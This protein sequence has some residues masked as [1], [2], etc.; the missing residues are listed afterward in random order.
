MK[1]YK[2]IIREMINNNNKINVIREQINA[3]KDAEKVAELCAKLEKI[4]V[5]GQILRDNYTYSLAAAALEAARDVYKDFDGK[6]L[7]EMTEKK[8]SKEMRRR[9]FS[10]WFHRYSWG[11]KESDSINVYAV[12]DNGYES[13][14]EA[15]I[16]SPLEF[17]E[18]EKR[19]RT[20]FITSDNKI[21]YH[22]I[23]TA[24]PS[25]KYCDNPAK[26]A[27]EIIKARKKYAAAVAKAYAAQ[28]ELNELL[29]ANIDHFRN[30]DQY[31]KGF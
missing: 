3:E 31:I 15:H 20:D 13:R 4:T 10:F 24:K 23:E 5:I 14:D 11:G 29:P 8:T 21:N 6:P 2:T 22:A 30:V 1:T 26:K 12:N 9:G 19:R 16:Y 25:G 28:C 17:D 7:G 27:G 18:N